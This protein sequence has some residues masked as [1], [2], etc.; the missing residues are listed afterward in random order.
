MTTYNKGQNPYTDPLTLHDEGLRRAWEDT[1]KRGLPPISIKPEEG[2]FLQF[3][4]TATGSRRALE[5]GTLGGYSGIW[6]ARGLPPGGKLITLE[7]EARYAQVALE[8]FTAAGMGDRVEIRVGDAHEL[9]TQMEQN[10]LFD[11]IFIDAEKT[12]YLA[13]YNWAVEHTQTGGVIAAHDA[14]RDHSATGVGLENSTDTILTAFYH[15]VSQD[16]R[17]FSTIYPAGNGMIL[18]VK[19]A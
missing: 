18:A 19:A 12:G 9:L 7:K 16:P 4:V 3:L 14:Y 1:P 10:V 8:H 5:I 15:R 2:S 11:F 6:I 17:V 13:Y